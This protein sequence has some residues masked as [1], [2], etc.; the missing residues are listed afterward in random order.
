MDD[1]I[2]GPGTPVR[3]RR[4]CERNRLEKQFLIDAYECVLA[5]RQHDDQH[6]TESEGLAPTDYLT[7]ERTRDLSKVSEAWARDAVDRH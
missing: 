3:L 5:I 7:V 2:I 4:T 6:G 1:P